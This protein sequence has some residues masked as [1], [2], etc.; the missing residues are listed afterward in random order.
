MEVRPITSFLVGWF[1]VAIETRYVRHLQE[2]AFNHALDAVISYF[3]GEGSDD[4]LNAIITQA[5]Y[6][7]RVI[8]YAL[9]CLEQG[10]L[11]AM[12]LII[13]LI[14]SPLLTILTAVFLGGTTICFKH[15]LDTDY[16]LGDESRRPK[17]ESSLTP[18]LAPRACAR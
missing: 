2:E 13:A 4:I 9:N 8:R 1:K 5:E 3:D 12:Y 17:R 16:S 15:V 6:A 7:G 11:A 10:L 18:R 14:I